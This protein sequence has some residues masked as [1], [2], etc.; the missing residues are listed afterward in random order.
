MVKALFIA[1]YS[2]P[3]IS[4]EIKKDT[5]SNKNNLPLNKSEVDSGL[6]LNREEVAELCK[7]KSMTT[8]W[9]WKRQ[10][11]LVPTH[12]AGR[13]PLYLRKDV[14]N[15]LKAKKGGQNV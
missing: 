5:E 6:F 4:E 9:S 3:E 8:L 2:Y 11:L 12:R 13:K 15:F 10:G 7:V 14:L 1:Y